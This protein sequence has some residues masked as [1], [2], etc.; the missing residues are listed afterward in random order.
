MQYSKSKHCSN[1]KSKFYISQ[2]YMYIVFILQCC[3]YKKLLDNTQKCKIIE[4][5][6]SRMQK[7]VK[8]HTEMQKHWTF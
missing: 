6:M 5:A 1:F 4:H 2:R 3:E 7:L 8:S